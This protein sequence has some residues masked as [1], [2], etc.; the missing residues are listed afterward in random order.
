MI[1][2]SVQQLLRVVSNDGNDAD[3]NPGAVRGRL[4]AGGGRGKGK[5]N[6]GSGEGIPPERFAL[7]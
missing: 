6:G 2:A 4:L 3:G 1:T 5:S 7:M